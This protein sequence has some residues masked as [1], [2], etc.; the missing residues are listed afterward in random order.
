MLL[1]DGIRK[2]EG[3]SWEV[4]VYMYLQHLCAWRW[5]SFIWWKKPD[6]FHSIILSLQKI[7]E[8]EITLAHPADVCLFWFLIHHQILTFLLLRQKKKTVFFCIMIKKHDLLCLSQLKLWLKKKNLTKKT[9]SKDA[10]YT[11]KYT[12]WINVF[13]Y[14]FDTYS[15]N[16]SNWLIT[17]C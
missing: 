11:T 10:S 5:A 15:S 7:Q 1:C 6:I 2:M 3:C 4:C 13:Y 14:N 17:R 12:K 9:H 16:C 8:T